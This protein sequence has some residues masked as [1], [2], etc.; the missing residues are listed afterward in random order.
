MSDLIKIINSLAIFFPRNYETFLSIIKAML[1]MNGSKTML[2][3]SRWTDESICYKTIERFYDRKIPWLLMNLF[4]LVNFLKL[5]GDLLIVSDETVEGKAGK[6]T[7][8]LDNFFSSIL[9]K[10]IKGLCFSGLSLI[11]SDKRKS[12]PLLMNQLIY[13]E[14]EKETLK[15]A[16]EKR[17]N[18][19]KS[20]N[21]VGRPKGSK[22]GIKVEP[23]LVATFRLLEGQLENLINVLKIK[24][25][26]FLGDGKYAN[27]TV[28]SLCKKY[29]L[30]LISKLQNNSALFFEYKDEYKG[31]GRK[32]IYGKKLDYTNIPLEYLVKEETKENTITRIYKMELLSKS[33]DDKLNVV[34]VQKIIHKKVA[35]VIFFSNDLTLDYEKII[36]FYS[37]RFQIEFNFRDSKEFWG[38]SDFMNTKEIRV[39]NASNFAFFMCNLSNIFLE[40]FREK[41]KN[42]K[43]GIRDLLSFL[44]ADYYFNRSLKLLQK[45]NTNI[46]I[47][48][49]IESITSIGAIHV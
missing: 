38:L 34:I 44:K 33:F 43:A 15:K 30:L 45:F 3:I 24:I 22:N 46:F 7:T 28:L 14:S 25:K 32:R 8:G 12:Y 20:K 42:D 4:L 41:Q 48:D 47:P 37:L 19:I 6:K 27:N 40:K 17:K 1:I 35:H 10:P 31:R 49:D 39:H 26:Y 29:G 36:D 9:Q 11:L 21:K 13:T 2:N 16:K 5:D 23:P 18:K